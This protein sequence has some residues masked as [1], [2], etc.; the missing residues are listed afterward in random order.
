MIQFR[1]AYFFLKAL[2]LLPL[3][4]L[5]IL[6]SGIHFLLEKVLGYRKNIVMENLSRAFPDYNDK[7]LKAVANNFYRHLSDVIVEGV[8]LFKFSPEELSTKMYFKNPEIFSEY[9]EKNK[10]VIA[11]AAHYG[12]WEWTAG[13]S[14][15]L[16]HK[17]LAVY[18]PLSNKYFDAFLRQ[19]RSKFGTRLVSMREIVRVLIQ[20]RNKNIPTV[21]L[22]ITDQSPV[23]EEIQYWTDFMNQNT[24]V[25]LG[26]E[27]IARQFG[28]AVVF[29]DVKKVD[30]G[31]YEVEII[32]VTDDASKEKP[33]FV[34]ETH[35]KI[36]E[37][38]IIAH[39]E[40]WL[41][42]HRRWKLTRKRER[43]ENNGMFR[44]QG[45]VIR[46]GKYES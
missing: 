13:L 3:K 38:R 40:Y 25:Y 10:S 15:G 46:E 12:N 9:F 18:K 35:V 20:H 28:M 29:L 2:S 7:E 30:R 45:Q 6:S 19:Q 21:S 37:E 42:S 23:W 44:F 43:E 14:I 26:P 27:K 41:W 4:I 1:L 33:Y 17:T 11:V 5:Y 24:A 34:T 22:F 36:L 8:K 31:R 39:P 16:Q 32:P